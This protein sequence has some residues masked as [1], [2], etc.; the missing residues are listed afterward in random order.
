MAMECA[1]FDFYHRFLIV[2]RQGNYV[3]VSP[4]EKVEAV[5]ADDGKEGR[6]QI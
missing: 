6:P 2:F 1:R 4:K 3:A 5:V